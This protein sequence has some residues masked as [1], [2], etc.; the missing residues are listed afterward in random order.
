MNTRR[1]FLI[2]AACAAVAVLAALAA[3]FASQDGAFSPSALV[4]MS[5]AEPIAGIARAADPNFSFVNPQEHYDGVYYYAMARDPLLRGPEHRLIDQA[6]YR[7]GHPMYGWLAGVVSLGQGR[8]VPWG[9]LLVTLLSAAVSGF[10]VSRLAVWFDRTPWG[11]L[12]VAMSPGL[13]YAATVSTTE[14]LGVA[15]MAMVFLFWLRER[16][17]VSGVLLILL[18]LTKEQYIA[19][20][21]GLVL[22]EL[23]QWRR[24]R[25]LPHRVR[26]RV[27]ALVAGPAA[28]SAWYM[29]VLASLGEFPATYQPGNLAAPLRGWFEAF[30]RAHVLSGGSFDQSEIGAITAPILIAVATVLLAAGVG[31]LRLRTPLDGALLG[32]VVI[33]SVMGWLTLTYPH[34]LLRNPSVALLLATGVLLTRP[35]GE[36]RP[37]TVTAREAISDASE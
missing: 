36:D 31:A 3:C 29:F 2:A 32:M 7:Y 9:L 34:E 26:V 23:A 14:W 10:A 35:R 33:T 21:A 6:A 12:L 28:L 18:C 37:P 24:T 22:W 25:R 1:E 4:K 19:V 13:L 11:G 15:L 20:P 16:I 17:A 27:I 5:R 30:A 8:L